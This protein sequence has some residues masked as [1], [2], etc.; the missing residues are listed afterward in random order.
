MGDDVTSG[1]GVSGGCCGGCDDRDDGVLQALVVVIALNYECR[2]DLAPQ[3]G[4]KANVA[5]DDVTTV[6]G[7]NFF[8]FSS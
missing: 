8:R 1:D 4:T 6:H 3:A 2:A 7:H 5:Q